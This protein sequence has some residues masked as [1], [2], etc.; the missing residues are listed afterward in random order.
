M[1]VINNNSNCIY[2]NFCRKK[3]Q[4][5]WT[6]DQKNSLVFFLENRKDLASG[7]FSSNDGKAQRSIN[8]QKAASYVSLCG[9]PKDATQCENVMKITSKF[10]INI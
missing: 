1:L 10:F 9:P 8:W 5:R 2:Y 3:S 7:R 4:Q 6:I